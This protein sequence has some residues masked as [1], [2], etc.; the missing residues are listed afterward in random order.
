MVYAENGSE[1]VGYVTS[2]FYSP[3]QGCNIG[4]AMLPNLFSMIGTKLEV[5]LPEPYA[6]GRVPAE[7]AQTPFK[8]SENPGTGYTQTGRKLET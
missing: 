7:V 6:N 8:V 3:N 5:H 1:P 4:Y 2:A